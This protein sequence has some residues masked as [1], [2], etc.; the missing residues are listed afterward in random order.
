MAKYNI[1]IPVYNEEDRIEKTCSS[2]L[3]FLSRTSEDYKFT[4]V[5]DGSTDNT[6]ALLKKHSA[7]NKNLAVLPLDENQ[8]KGAAVKSGILNAEGEYACFIDGDMAYSF[9]HLIPMF[10]T[11]QK[12]D[13][14]IGSRAL[15]FKNSRR[16]A[17]KRRI[18]G[19]GFNF[20][21]RIM[22]GL[23]YRDTQAGLKGFKLAKA[24]N[25]FNHIHDSRFWFD[26]EVLFI[27][28][29]YGYSIDEIPAIVAQQHTEK[30]TRVRLI[31]DTMKM[32]LGLFKIHIYNIR[33]D[34]N[35]NK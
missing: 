10:K 12:K 6:V 21:V 7:V 5:D 13:V 25:I 17:I 26:V 19:G 27:A 31:S 15:G 32:F 30:N 35:L 11:L 24:K 28:K 3:E 2:V 23:P 18:L 14:V 16:I 20:L 8:G 29:K 34:Y 9:N 33:G 22:T 1:I 4:F